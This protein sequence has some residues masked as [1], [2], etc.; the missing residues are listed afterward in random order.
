MLPSSLLQL[1]EKSYSINSRYGNDL[2]KSALNVLQRFLDRYV[3][4]YRLVE[5]WRGLKPDV[6]N[7]K[8]LIPPYKK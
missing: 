6:K 2:Q 7:N 8:I 4:F 1:R 3:T 5:V